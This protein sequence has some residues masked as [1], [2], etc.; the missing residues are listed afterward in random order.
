MLKY[1]FRYGENHKTAHLEGVTVWVRSSMA[2]MS[3]WRLILSGAFW[4][5]MKMGQEAGI[6]MQ[7][8]SR[9]LERKHNTLASFPHWYL[10][11]LGVDPEFQGRGHAGRLLRTMFRRTDAEGLPCYLET[12][13]EKNVSFYE[14]L[15]FKVLD[16][17]TIPDS[18]LKMWL[19]LRDIP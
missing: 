10:M 14:H 17:Y 11:L 12:E 5:S 19:M 4:P 3:F 2:T 7:R 18:K 16:T 13:T 9:Q 1:G 8:L 15:G 6:K